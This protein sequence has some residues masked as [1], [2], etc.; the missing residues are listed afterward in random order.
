VEVFELE[1]EAVLREV[2]SVVSEGLFQ[3]AVV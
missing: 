2:D 3:V 1:Q